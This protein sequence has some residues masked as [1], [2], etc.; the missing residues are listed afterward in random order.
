MTLNW[1]TWSNPVAIWWSALLVVSATN[2]GLWLWLRGSLRAR[3][4]DRRG[5]TSRVE[6]LVLLCAAYVFVCA[7]R[8]VLPRADV[9]RICLFDTWLSSVFVGRSVATI[10]EVCFAVQW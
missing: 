2:I 9:Q 3:T 10:A 1:L 5:G 8:S 6:W 7:F 4:T